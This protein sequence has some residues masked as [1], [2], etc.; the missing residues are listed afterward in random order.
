MNDAT[1]TPVM[2]FSKGPF[3]SVSLSG[4]FREIAQVHSFF[5]SAKYWNIDRFVL[6]ATDWNR[7]PKADFLRGQGVGK[8]INW[9][10]YAFGQEAVPSLASYCSKEEVD[11]QREIADAVY[12]DCLK[13]GIGFVFTVVLPKFPFNN[14]EVI[15][16]KLPDLFHQDGKFDLSA[17]ENL[18]I[19]EATLEEIRARYPKMAGF[20]I[21][22]AEGAGKTIHH[23]DID[24]LR[25]ADL[26]LG[27]W[28][29]LLETYSLKHKVEMTVFA[30]QYTHSRGTRSQSHKI[31]EKYPSLAI[32]EDN[33]WPEENVALP[34]LGYMGSAYA[35]NLAA[36][37]PLFINSLL[38]TEYMGQG[39]VPSVFPMFIQEGLRQA[40]Y[41]NAFGVNGRVMYWDDYGTLE[42]WNLINT[43]LFCSLARNPDMDAK[44]LL[45]EILLRRFGSKHAADVLSEALMESQRLTLMSM[46]LN[47]I[48]I[49]DHSAFPQSRN[50]NRSY[51]NNPLAMKAVDDLFK[52]PGTAL[53]KSDDDSIRAGNEWRQQLRLVTRSVEDYL[54]EKDIA[55]REIEVLCE[56]VE[57]LRNDLSKEDFE[58][59]TKS[60]RMWIEYTKALKLFAEAAA[61][62]AR[63]VTGEG[64]EAAG[65]HTMTEVANSMERLAEDFGLRFSE[66]AL[67]CM[68]S[69]LK[70]MA[71]FLRSL[72]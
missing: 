51:F 40:R 57:T 28:L 8:V 23:F 61:L 72:I 65:L 26:W 25:E 36:S 15:M 54:N 52:K 3:Q 27:N 53:F 4:T 9:E 29:A 30:H 1:N 46:T 49:S 68:P 71:E 34:H 20:E 21:W 44:E 63:Q 42:G 39:R 17:V 62:H 45:R 32:M 19:I 31:F 7:G 11:Y 22:I 16:E 56:K 47:G 38:D 6:L 33:T 67:F 50:L 55:I 35:Q 37:N 70:Q 41:V 24:D 48:S 64:S 14:K 60:Y 69:K 59:V 43:E 2:P 58:F 10:S 12:Q 66:N 13:Y 5:E 18:T